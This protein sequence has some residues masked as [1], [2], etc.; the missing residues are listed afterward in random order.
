MFKALVLS[1]VGDEVTAAVE[2]L[3]EARLPEGDVTV[4][5]EAFD[6]ELQGRADRPQQG[7]AGAQLSRMCRASTSPAPWSRAAI[8]TGGR[9]MP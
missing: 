9:A 1:K 4:A 3:D 2:Q 8:P 6:A 7:A 5:V